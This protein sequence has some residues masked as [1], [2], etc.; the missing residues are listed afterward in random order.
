MLPFQTHRSF[1]TRLSRL[2]YPIQYIDI[3][4]T[5]TESQAIQVGGTSIRSPQT[6]KDIELSEV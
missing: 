3:D 5:L 2:A 4:N 1:T 6:S